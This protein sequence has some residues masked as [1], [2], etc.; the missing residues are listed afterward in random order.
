MI[1]SFIPVRIGSKSIPL[2]NIKEINGKPLVQWVIDTSGNSRYIKKVIVST[3]SELISGKV[4]NC[5]I[6]WRGKET[7]TD[8]ASSELP[9]IEFCN[10]RNN[11][12]LIVFIQATSPLISAD[13]IDSGIEKILNNECD[14]VVSV[15]RQKKFIWDKKGLPTYDLYKRPRRQDWN[16]YLVENGGFYISKVNDILK[17]GCRVSGKIKLVE[18]S[19]ETYYEIDNPL[20]WMIVENLLKN[21]NIY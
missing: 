13:E 3:D 17:S 9:L 2:K 8:F 10:T 20:D 19:E 7:A 1:T 18:C 6:F 5:E 14:S 15:V 16:G 4:K 11:N 12:D 21:G